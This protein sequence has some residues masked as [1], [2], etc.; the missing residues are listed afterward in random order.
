M[1]IMVRTWQQTG[2]HDSNTV[3]WELTSWSSNRRQRQLSGI[4]VRLWNLNAR[5]QIHTSN[6]TTPP[7]PSQRVPLTGNQVFKW[8][9][10]EPFSFKPAYPAFLEN[11]ENYYS[12][13]Q[14]CNSGL[15]HK[16]ILKTLCWA[17]EAR[18]PG[19]Q[20][21]IRNDSIYVKF[22]FS[23]PL[24]P[25]PLSLSHV[26]VHMYILECMHVFYHV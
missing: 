18:Q 25:S 3:C 10:P 13:F 11:L 6:K 24:P 21:H 15:K 9:T 20:K 16:L 17:K 26:C 1:I 8:T 4:S 5:L 12:R 22:C 7:S 23:L 14:F 2:R 19:S